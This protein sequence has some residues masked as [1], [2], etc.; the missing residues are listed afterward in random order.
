MCDG[1]MLC[2]G[3]QPTPTRWPTRCWPPC[4]AACSWPR[5]YAALPHRATHCRLRSPTWRPLRPRQQVTGRHVDV[6]E[7]T[8]RCPRLFHLAE[9]GSAQASSMH[10]LRPAHEIVLTSTLDHDE[11][12][13]ILGAAVG[14]AG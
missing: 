12:T 11:Q 5:R 3:G 2:L 6:S 14:P 7:L 8:G 1:V 4:K 13:A 9:A 10:G